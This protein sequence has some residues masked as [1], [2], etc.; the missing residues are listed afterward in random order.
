VIVAS[1]S[2]VQTA[3]KFLKVNCTSF[4]ILNYDSVWRSILKWEC[5][6]NIDLCINFLFKIFFLMRKYNSALLWYVVVIKIWAFVTMS[7]K[8]MR[9]L[10]TG[11]WVL[12]TEPLCDSFLHLC[13]S[14]AFVTTKVLLQRAEKWKSLGANTPQNLTD[15]IPV[16]AVRMGVSRTA[17]DLAPSDIRLFSPLKKHLGG[18]RFQSVVEVQL[19]VAEFEKPR[20]LRWWNISSH[21]TSDKCL[22]HQDAYVGK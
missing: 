14:L 3:R 8:W 4:W 13:I 9:A 21:S 20:T 15:G 16:A 19:T 1:G 7:Y 5:T 11:F 22:N 6:V 18:H 12:R 2:D 17:T 10:S